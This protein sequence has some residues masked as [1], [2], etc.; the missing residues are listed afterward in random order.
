MSGGFPGAVVFVLLILAVGYAFYLQ[1]PGIATQNGNTGGLM[2]RLFPGIYQGA[3]TSTAREVPADL[4]AGFTA[5]DLSPYFREARITG[6]VE[7]NDVRILRIRVPRGASIAGWTVRGSFGSQLIGGEGAVGNGDVRVP[8][9]DG[10]LMPEHDQA[11]LLDASGK[12]AD[13]WSSP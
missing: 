8:L 10:V 9:R 6:I 11:V 3:A 12:L 5:R 1:L 13:Y 4:P 7:E 2:Q